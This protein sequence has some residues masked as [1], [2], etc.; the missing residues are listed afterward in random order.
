MSLVVH[1]PGSEADVT[2]S[3]AATLFVP[4]RRIPIVG[5]VGGIGSGKSA[6][7][8]WVAQRA[9]VAV[10]NAD[11]MGHEALQDADV[12]QALCKRFGDA[13][14]AADGSIARPALAREVFG[15]D[16]THR[17]A[18]HDLECIVHP[19]IDR[20]IVDGVAVATANEQEAVLL[21]AAVLLEAGWR[22][23]CDLVVFIDTPDD[24]RLRRV[25]E[26]RGW[27]ENELHRRESNQWS[28]MDKRRESDFIVIN[29]RD[30]D[31]AGTQLMDI[32]KQNGIINEVPV[33]SQN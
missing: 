6:V 7:A 24:V 21:D 26:L 14:L 3:A 33:V 19:E 17:D 27:T 1:I 25:S 4:P 22:N 10:L 28:L 32:L 8:D 23:K 20:R 2:S 18:R 12:K 31:F 13:I 16:A 5:I 15:S 11:T 30:L 9:K 29:D